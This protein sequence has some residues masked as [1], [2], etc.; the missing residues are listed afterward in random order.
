MKIKFLRPVAGFAYWENDITDA[1][2]NERA[3]SLVAMG[4]AVIIPDT[5]GPVN[6]LPDGLPAREI[7]FNAG[8]ETIADIKNAT[9]TLRDIPGITAKTATAINK[10]LNDK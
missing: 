3:A 1:L 6:K 10:W 9:H 5:E 2:P 4:A 7:L 8:L